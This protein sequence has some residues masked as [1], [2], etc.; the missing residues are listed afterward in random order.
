MSCTVVVLIPRLYCSDH[1]WLDYEYVHDMNYY[2]GSSP[3]NPLSATTGYPWVKAI[4][5]L[6][7]VGPH[8]TVANGT[9]VPPPLIVG[10]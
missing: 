5:D 1:E 9:P 3:G 7:E 8:H 2:Y 6:F 4:A 10:F